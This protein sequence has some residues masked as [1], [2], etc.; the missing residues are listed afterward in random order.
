MAS[1]FPTSR[2]PGLYDEI[3][4]GRPR[5]INDEQIAD[6]LLNT[7]QTDSQDSCPP[8]KLLIPVRKG[9][10]FTGIKLGHV[11]K[12]HPQGGGKNSISDSKKQDFL[13]P[14]SLNRRHEVFRQTVP[15]L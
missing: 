15:L 8:E 1:P 6:L 4:P 7:T 5:S 12:P 14:R 3:R 13:P 9:A 11:W 10:I 2:H